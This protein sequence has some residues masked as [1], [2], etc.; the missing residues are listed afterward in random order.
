MHLETYSHYPGGGVTSAGPRPHHAQFYE[1]LPPSP[2][3]HHHHTSL[4]P[5]AST[6]SSME[7]PPLTSKEA[8]GVFQFPPPEHYLEAPP[9]LIKQEDFSTNTQEPGNELKSF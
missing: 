4:E 2:H 3:T 8:K 9:P 1:C 7:S 6:P 5:L